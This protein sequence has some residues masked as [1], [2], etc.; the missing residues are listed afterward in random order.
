M[1]RVPGVGRPV[2]VPRR[3]AP[4]QTVLRLHRPAA[5]PHPHRVGP[6]RG[7]VLLQVVEQGLMAFGEVRGLGRPV[8][9][10]DVDVRVVVAVPRRRVAVVPDALEVGRR[11]AGARRAD[12]E[13]TAVLVIEDFERAT[14]S[15]VAASQLVGRNGRPRL[16]EVERDS[17]EKRAVVGDMA[18]S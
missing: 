16:T 13:V 10:L 11:R 17:I 3:L 18:R 14:V 6:P 5:R 15:L 4:E 12:E 1:H 2:P 9:H 7:L 8:D